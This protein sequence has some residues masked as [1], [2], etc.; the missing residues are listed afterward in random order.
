MSQLIG[1]IWDKCDTDTNTIDSVEQQRKCG[2]ILECY[3]LSIPF[4]QILS[5]Q[6]ISTSLYFQ[7]SSE[8]KVLKM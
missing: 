5:Q 2:S 8:N 7:L 1:H 6:H 4:D 3:T